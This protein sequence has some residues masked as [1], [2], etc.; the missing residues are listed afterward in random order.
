M[1]VREVLR[2]NGI[3]YGRACHSSLREHEL[4]ENGRC[5]EFRVEENA[6]DEMVQAIFALLQEPGPEA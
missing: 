4:L 5:G 3:T 1:V 6:A 2:H